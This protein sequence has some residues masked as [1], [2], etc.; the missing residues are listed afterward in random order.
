MLRLTAGERNQNPAT[1][2]RRALRPRLEQLEDRI[3]PSSVTGQW[4]GTLTELNYGGNPTLY[5]FSMDLVQT[6]DSVTGTVL[7]QVDGES[8]YFA[9]YEL[10]GSV[11]GNSFTFSETTITQQNSPPGV[12]WL[13]IS[14]SLQLSADGSSMAGT[15]SSEGLYSGTINETDAVVQT[16]FQN[17]NVLHKLLYAGQQLNVNLSLTNGLPTPIQGQETLYLS[18]NQNPTVQSDMQ[19]TNVN[20]L[21]LQPGQTENLP[22][23]PGMLNVLIP[24]TIQPGTSYYLKAT[25]SGND[26]PT[27]NSV[28]VSPGLA[29]CVNSQGQA[30]SF[31][32]TFAQSVFDSAVNTVKQGNPPIPV[33]T[34]ENGIGNFIQSQEN[35]KALL[36]YYP[37]LDNGVPAVGFGSDLEDK[38]TKTVNTQFEEIIN[39]YLAAH[40]ELGFSFQDFLNLNPNAYI[41]KATAQALFTSGFQTAQQYVLNTYPQITNLNQQAALMDIAYNIGTGGLSKFTSMNADLALNT[42]FG[43]A[44]AGL[45]LVNSLR[46]TQIPVQRTDADFYLLTSF[47]GVSDLL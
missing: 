26:D 39:A 40:P 1:D 3:T 42:P 28:A 11:S 45:E 27:D 14:G 31:S 25:F 43:F 46:T 38:T 44:C 17:T 24:N 16:Q 2:A 29:V 18:T 33:I 23:I 36:K 21:S 15:W 10:T 12:T 8:Q 9:E 7:S 41:D 4:Q 47:P 19:L 6:Q 34:S 5:D 35:S 37:Y 30:S 22:Q 32:S 13:I 20:S